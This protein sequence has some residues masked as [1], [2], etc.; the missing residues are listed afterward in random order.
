MNR[1]HRRKIVSKSK[2]S[3]ILHLTL[4]IV[5]LAIFILQIFVFQQPDGFF[6]MVLCIAC[7]LA[8][9]FSTIKLCMINEKFEN[10]FWALI[11]M[12]CNLP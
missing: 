9:L 11:E 3:I 5:A 1:N 7:I 2:K 6:G 10:A 8:V 4:L 12:I